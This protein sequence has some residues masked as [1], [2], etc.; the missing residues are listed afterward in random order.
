[1]KIRH[2]VKYAVAGFAAAATVVG[3]VAIK[4]AEHQRRSRGAQESQRITETLR[5]RGIGGALPTKPA[6]GAAGDRPSP[7]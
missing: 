2:A 1:M 4:V 5:Q 3:I 6:E 7:Q